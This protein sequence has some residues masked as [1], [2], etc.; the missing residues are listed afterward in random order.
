MTK[1]ATRQRKALLQYLH[2]HADEQLTARQIG[3]ALSGEEISAS[4]VYRNLAALE[5]AG[6]V[7]RLSKSGAR[8]IFFQ[9]AGAEHCKDCLHLS[10]K[11]CGKTIHMDA[12]E[13]ERLIQSVAICDKFKIDKTDTVLYGV[14]GECQQGKE[15][16]K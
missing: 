1:Y 4:A 7:R 12:D 9:Y 10:C 2:S 11:K 14:C 8:E 3:E 6:Q 13:A 5:Q 15:A 16:Q